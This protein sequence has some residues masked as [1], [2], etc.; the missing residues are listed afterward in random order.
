W[1]WYYWLFTTDATDGSIQRVATS[2]THTR[3]TV[4]QAGEMPSPVVLQVKFAANGARIRPMSNARMTD[5][6]TAEVT[7]PV[8]VWFGGSRNFTA[9]LSFGGRKIEQILLDPHRRFPDRDPSDN[10]WPRAV[11]GS[12]EARPAP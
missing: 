1:F 4:H 2:G 3:V 11:V 6:V 12:R 5:S 10:V 9:D 8:D 7:Y